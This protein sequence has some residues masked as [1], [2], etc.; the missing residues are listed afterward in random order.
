MRIITHFLSKAFLLIIVSSASVIAQTNVQKSVMDYYEQEPSMQSAFLG[1]HVV[2]MMEDSAIVDINSNKSMLPASIVKIFTTAA[3][4]NY[5]GEDFR[6]K[7][8]ISHTGSVDEKGVLNGNLV[9]HGAGD[10]TLGS[11]YFPDQKYF[12]DTIVQRV[13]DYGITSI[14]G[15]IIIDCSIFDSQSIPTSWVWED[16][17][18]SY[19]AGVYP[20][21]MNDNVFSITFTNPNKDKEE[22]KG[23]SKV[24]NA[25]PPSVPASPYELATEDSINFE[26]KN[27]S[28]VV[29]GSIPAPQE[30]LGLELIQRFFKLGLCDYRQDFMPVVIPVPGIVDTIGVLTSPSLQEIVAV[31]NKKSINNYADH[32]VKYLGYTVYNDGSFSVGT[33]VVTD[34]IDSV[35]VSSHGV[36]LY[37]GSGLS[38]Y[39]VLTPQHVTAFLNSL[40]PLSFYSTFYN[41]LSEPEND[42]TL[43]SYDFP[44]YMYGKIHAKTGSMTRVRNIAGYMTTKS[45][46]HISFCIML[47]GHTCD[48]TTSR[49]NITT[50]LTTIYNTY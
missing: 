35:G 49:K 6:Y 13:I 48:A 22:R 2:D 28:F 23:L 32:L 38:R 50:L 30:I 31:T 15:E 46:K 41:S 19:A 34:F 37:D 9:V 10:P 12:I 16:L 5:M 25:N 20:I 7:T 33:N 21:A 44:E 40:T 29:R 8:Y 18:R 42:G 27:G 11:K 17:G 43:K 45:G 4:L 36:Y 24:N 26:Q 14:K 39:N 3:A 47:N 1:I